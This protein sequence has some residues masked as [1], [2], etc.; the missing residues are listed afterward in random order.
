MSICT[1][2]SNDSKVPTIVSLRRRFK[3]KNIHNQ[4]T[5]LLEEYDS[6]Q[7]QLALDHQMHHPE[8]S[9]AKLKDLNQEVSGHVQL[10]DLASR[11]MVS[12]VLIPLQKLSPENLYQISISNML[13]KMIKPR[14]ERCLSKRNEL[15]MCRS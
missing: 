6:E 2:G 14:L 4:S 13:L 11:S 15:T 10:L 9:K 3:V 1:H 5:N 12:V 8:Q 7:E